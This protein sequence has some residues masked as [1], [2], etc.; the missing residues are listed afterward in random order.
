[1][2]ACYCHEDILKGN[3]STFKRMKAMQAATGS[4]KCPWKGNKLVSLALGHGK[5]IGERIRSCAT[6]RYNEAM[7]I[8]PPDV[9]SH[10]GSAVSMWKARLSSR[11]ESKLAYAYE[12]SS[13]K[14]IIF[15]CLILVGFWLACT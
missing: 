12:S 4:S 1:M 13:H 10:V 8:A 9:R 6:L 5:V 7:A 14:V 2:E 11:V 15:M 3:A